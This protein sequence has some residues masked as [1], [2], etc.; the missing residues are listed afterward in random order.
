MPETD[1]LCIERTFL[2]FALWQKSPTSAVLM[3][4]LDRLALHRW[5]LRD[6]QPTFEAKCD[7]PSV[8][9]Q[10]L[11]G[12]VGKRFPTLGHYSDAHHDDPLGEPS[13]GDATDD[14]ADIVRELQ[15]AIWQ[16][17][18]VS[19]DDGLWALKFGFDTHWGQHLRN[20]SRYLHI[21]RP[22]P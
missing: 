13:V 6:P 20:L 12:L 22:Q 2:D 15:D 9:W 8:D 1:E 14:L 19:R 3:L 10:R 7:S 21:K 11:Y 16:Y 5:E 17:D 4:W 18:N